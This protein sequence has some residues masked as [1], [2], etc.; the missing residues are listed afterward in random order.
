M[1]SWRAGWRQSLLFGCCCHCCYCYAWCRHHHHHLRR[2][3]LCLSLGGVATADTGSTAAPLVETPALPRGIARYIPLQQSKQILAAV[4]FP[5]NQEK[6]EGERT[7]R[8]SREKGE[9]ERTDRTHRQ[10]TERETEHT[11]R[12][13]AR[14][15]ESNE[16]GLL[17]F[18]HKHVCVLRA[19]KKEKKKEHSA[20]P[21]KKVYGFFFFFFS[22]SS[23]SHAPLAHFSPLRSLLSLS[24]FRDSARIHTNSMSRRATASR[25]KRAKT[26]QRQA[27][28]SL[29]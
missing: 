20:F 22:S 23:P 7:E 8:G 13:R 5:F 28:S 25:R 26:S 1:S 4:L 16:D 11:H 21:K 2:R 24:F 17:S 9:T 27:V 14:D 19:Q 6:R 10:N 29:S 3:R 18:L 15:E 12:E